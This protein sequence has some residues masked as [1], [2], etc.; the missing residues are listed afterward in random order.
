MN[1]KKNQHSLILELEK[2]LQLKDYAKLIA[3]II[4][5][6]KKINIKYDLSKPNGT[7]EKVIGY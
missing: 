4:L 1:K 2:I 6:K 7:K 5:P 3:K